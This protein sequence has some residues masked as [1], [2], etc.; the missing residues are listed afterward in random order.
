[1]TGAVRLP[2]ERGGWWHHYVCPVHGVELEHVDLLTGVF[3]AVG[4][5][6]RYGCRIDTPGVRGAWTVLAH[7]ACACEIRAMAR[8]GEHA[9]AG[10]LL[11][12]YGELY[13]TLAVHEG[14]DSW[15]LRGRLFHQALTE[16]VWA[17]VVGEASK[18]TGRAAGLR[19]ALAGAAASARDV[20]VGQGK[21]SSNYTAWLNAAGAVC[22]GDPAWLSGPH[23]TLA[24]IEAATHE[25]GWEWE[26]STYYH[27]FVLR[28]Y[29]HTFRAFP[30]VAPPARLARMARVLRVLQEP[31]CHLPA[32]HDG[33][34]QRPGYDDELAEL[35]ELAT[36]LPA[37]DVSGPVTVFDSVGYAVL[38]GGG[39]RAVVDYGPHGGSHGHRDKLA[40]YLYG[41]AEPWQ[42]DP[43]QVPYGHAVWR[44]HYASTAAHPTFAVDGLEQAEC[45]GRLMRADASGAEVACDDAYPGVRATRRLTLGEEGLTDELT[46]V[47]D[48]P[49]QVTLHLRPAVPIEVRRDPGEVTRTTWQGGLNGTHGATALAYFTA[50]PGPGP[51]DDPQRVTTWIDWTAPD[52]AEVTFRSVYRV[53]V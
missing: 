27:T 52:T 3:P 5:P 10:K 36:D 20:L 15:M 44:R 49:R 21:F 4:V 43:G 6:C 30:D 26:G 13:R 40:L 38:R 7:Q 12:E 50:C 32:L 8:R 18:I 25:D 37:G 23:G 33:P 16:A 53:G 46:V 9:E 42:P 1:M 31:G 35:R 11:D 22:D 28:A 39:L 51:A 34:Y 14:A 41:D 47:C 17:V 24:H 2:A 29:L 48:R 45:A 19:E